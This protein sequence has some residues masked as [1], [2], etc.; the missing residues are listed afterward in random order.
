VIK[1]PKGSLFFLSP[2]VNSII[3]TENLPGNFTVSQAFLPL[4]RKPAD[5]C[6]TFL[7]QLDRA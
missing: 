7:A 2:A 3:G 4:S 5:N 6:H 1:G